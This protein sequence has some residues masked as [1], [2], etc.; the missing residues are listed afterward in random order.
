MNAPLDAMTA[1]LDE[2]VTERI[3][4][5]VTANQALKQELAER[6]RVEAALRE[7]ERTSRSVLD[8][9]PG[10]VAILSPDGG[11]EIMKRDVGTALDPDC[12]NALR[13]VLT[14]EV[15]AP[16]VELPAVQFV[17]ALAEDYLQAA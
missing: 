13:V 16:P 15:V 8:G 6:R 12:F 3:R 10:L 7:S 17:P 4:E 9:I 5:L 14:S 1:D 11:L 2:R